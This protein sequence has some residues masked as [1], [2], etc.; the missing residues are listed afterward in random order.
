MSDWISVNLHKVF[1]DEAHLA[2]QLADPPAL[3]VVN[4]V[5][6]LYPVVFLER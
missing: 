2:P 1:G 4:L 5:Y 6:N 3:T